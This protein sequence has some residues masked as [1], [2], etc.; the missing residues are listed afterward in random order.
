[1]RRS[2]KSINQ[3]NVVPYIDELVAGD[4]HGQHA[5]NPARSAALRRQQADVRRR[6]GGDAAQ[7]DALAAD[8]GGHPRSG[9]RD[10]LVQRVR[11]KQAQL[12][13]QPVVIAA[14]RSTRYEDVLGV[15]DRLQQGGAKRVGLLARPATR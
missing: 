14:D 8:K 6:A 4:L 3:I 1:M 12:P 13:D 2:R 15:L 10:E 9:S 11:Q 5:V 7:W